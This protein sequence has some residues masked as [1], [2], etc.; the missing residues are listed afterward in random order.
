M[1][2]NT[3]K[4]KRG[5]EFY[6]TELKQ[7]VWLYRIVKHNDYLVCLI[8]DFDAATVDDFIN[9]D[10][11]VLKSNKPTGSSIKSKPKELTPEQ[12]K[13]KLDLTVFFASQIRVMPFLCDNCNQPL[14]AFT[15]FEK[16]AC[17]AHILPKNEKH[18]FPTVALHPANKMF[19]CGKGGCHSFYD[20]ATPAERS[21]MPCFSLAMEGFN[22]FRDILTIPDKIRAYKYL[23]ID[24]NPNEFKDED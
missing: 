7:S 9:V 11:G 5:H 6:H 24:Y 1:I 13:A 17:I 23:N 12:R 10:P 20:N 22:V 15:D 2:S 18:G 3:P 21:Q 4:P 8:P 19:L 16:R 14:Y